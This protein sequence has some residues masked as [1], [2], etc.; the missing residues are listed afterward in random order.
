[1]HHLRELASYLLEEIKLP[2]FSVNSVYNMGRCS[3]NMEVN[4]N[5]D[6]RTFAMNELLNLNKKYNGRI[7]ATAGP[8]ADAKFWIAMENAYHTGVECVQ[9]GGYLTGC[10]GLLNKIA[11]RSDGVIVPCDQM[12]HI[13]LGKI[14]KDDLREVWLNHSEFERLRSRYSMSLKDFGFCKKCKYTNYCTGGCPAT[15]YVLC[16]KEN[17]PSPDTCLRRF[18]L[19]GGR[20]SNE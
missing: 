10:G 1:V 12:G 13:N 4:L 5:I 20:L 3:K 8:L 7:I 18:Y 6:E 16:G 2:S 17:H 19:E 9:G 14:N 11:V 15:A